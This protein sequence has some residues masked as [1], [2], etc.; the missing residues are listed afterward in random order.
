I[1]RI[2]KQIGVD[3]A[4]GKKKVFDDLVSTLASMSNPVQRSEYVKKSAERLNIEEDYIWQQLSKIGAGKNILRSTQPTIKASS[5]QTARER[6]ERL[7]IECL[8]QCPRL[9]SK[10]K[11]L[12]K[13][14]FTNS[15]HIELIELL[16][17]IDEGK[18]SIELGDLINNCSS[19]ETRDLL[20]D[21]IAKKISLRKNLLSNVEEIEAELN[22]CIKKIEDFRKR[23]SKLAILKENIADKITISQTLMNIRKGNRT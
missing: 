9:I 15:C 14:D 10:T 1:D 20:S 5:K 4:E 12:K 6:I 8:I 18:E 17:N 23:E 7:L 13:E 19:K 22:G 16:W 11:H 21:I 2:N 3:T